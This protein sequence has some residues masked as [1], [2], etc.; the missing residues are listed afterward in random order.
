MTGWP[1]CPIECQAMCCGIISFPPEFVEKNKLLFQ[2]KTDIKVV[3]APPIGVKVQTPDG[4][5]VFLDRET[6]KC[7]IYEDRPKICK[8]F[9]QSP[10]LLCP[11]F[12]MKGVLRTPRESKRVIGYMDRV[13]TERVG[14][15]HYALLP[16]SKR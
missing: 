2:V 3:A 15:K 12:N 10:K 8:E 1:E 11:Y 16:M 6:W 14:R 9:G 7:V 5:C 4:Q 13:I